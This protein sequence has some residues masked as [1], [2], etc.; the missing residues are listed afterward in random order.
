MFDKNV[1]G[2]KNFQIK[3]YNIFEKF[4]KPKYLEWSYNFYL[5]FWAKNYD[6]K[7]IRN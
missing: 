3:F 4:S 1:Q 6:K 2:I 7:K 5:K